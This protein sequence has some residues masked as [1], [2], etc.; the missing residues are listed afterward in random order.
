MDNFERHTLRFP[1][2]EEP[3]SPQDVHGIALETSGHIDPNNLQR[4]QLEAIRKL[5]ILL[6]NSTH[7]HKEGDTYALQL[8]M[9]RVQQFALDD[10]RQTFKNIGRSIGWMPETSVNGT[11][12]LEE[13][14][15]VR[16]GLLLSRKDLPPNTKIAV[17]TL[18]TESTITL[19]P[20]FE[21]QDTLR[22]IYIYGESIRTVDTYPDDPNGGSRMAA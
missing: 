8:P 21:F 16:Q 22:K 12:V 17:C 20:G 4:M 11:C 7:E 9:K 13:I 18:S 3:L 1:S 5:Y 10:E 19:P 6:T 14:H 15:P 2:A